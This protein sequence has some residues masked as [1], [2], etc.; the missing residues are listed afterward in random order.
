MKNKLLRNILTIKE[1]NSLSDHDYFLYAPYKNIT[2]NLYE[3]STDK[4]QGQ[5]DFIYKEFNGINNAEDKHYY[6]AFLGITSY[7]Q[8]SKGGRGKYIE[9][10]LAAVDENC[11]I[12]NKISDLPKLLLF[13]EIMRKSKLFGKEKLDASEKKSLRLCPWNFIAQNDATTDLCYIQGNTISF[14]ELKNRV[15]SGGVASR[16]EIFDNKFRQILNYFIEKEKVFE[17]KNTKY[18][19]LDF[20]RYFKINKLRLSLG[21]LFNTDGEYATKEYDSQYGFYS[22]SKECFIRLK[23]YLENNDIYIDKININNLFLNLT[24]DKNLT[25]EISSVYGH[26][27]SNY[28]YQKKVDLN[29]LIKNKY[30]DIWL[31]QLLAIDERTNLLKYHDNIILSLKRHISSSYQF[32]KLIDN[33]INNYNTDLLESFLKDLSINEELIPKGRQKEKYLMDILY[34]I[35]ANEGDI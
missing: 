30:D 22:S 10:K 9:K 13:K 7:F 19:L 24:L 14:L 12:D 17:Y 28:L 23:H 3:L 8:A 26:E 15:D 35:I 29:S 21:I 20:Y 18:Q 16:R 5:F 31:F 27:I 6:E 1:S 2:R 34:F 25:I 32:K 33:F 4:N 11:C